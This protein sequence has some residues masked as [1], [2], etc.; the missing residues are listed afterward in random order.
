MVPMNVYGV[1]L[2]FKATLAA[3]GDALYRDPYKKPPEAPVLYLK[4]ANTWIG[5]GAP[6]PCPRGVSR[7][8]MG[9]TLGVV[10]GHGYAIVNDVSIP[11]ESYFRPAIREQ[12]RDGFCSIGPRIDHDALVDPHRAE[13][14]IFINDELR[15]VNSTANLVRPIARLVADIS[16]FMTLHHGD[17]LLVGQPD[18]APLAG[19][20]DRVRVEIE[21]LG[22]LE[23][24][25]E[26][27][28]L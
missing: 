11:H 28:D 26:A 13:I 27:E 23:N 20:G 2:N 15:A 5:N 1:A 18:N 9:G 22:A 7:L 12:C 8:R 6:I 10:I 21:G 17:M 16:E 24:P 3:L 4:P 14:R 25:V 19:V